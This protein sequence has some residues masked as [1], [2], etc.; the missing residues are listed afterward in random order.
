MARVRFIKP[1][2]FLNED[3]AALHPHARLLYIGLW[4]LA[5]R[6]GVL[7]DRPL[8]IKA[9]LF[10]YE[11]IDINGYL[12][13]LSPWLHRYTSEGVGYIRIKSFLEHQSPH[14]TEKQT[15]F[16]INGELTVNSPLD[17]GKKKDSTVIQVPI[18]G[19]VTLEQ[20][21]ISKKA[22]KIIFP[23]WLDKKLFDDWLE[24]RR[25]IKKPAT[26]KAVQL[27]VSKLEKFYNA[28]K[29]V[30]KIIEQ[31]IFNSW[32]DFYELKQQ[33]INYAGNSGNNQKNGAGKPTQA[34]ISRTA[35]DEAKRRNY[36]EYQRELAAEAST[37]S[38]KQIGME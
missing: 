11:N 28:G 31:S 26:E 10:P 13:V 27:A 32:Q 23:V 9:E 1:K 12:T 5:D 22:E 2:F 29:D 38:L 25:R 24:M 14:H 30:S 20:L 18:T 8:R 7:E 37:N 35:L 34:E 6:N 21:P 33:G 3:L 4:C 16:P 15:G 17:H 36:E 19:T